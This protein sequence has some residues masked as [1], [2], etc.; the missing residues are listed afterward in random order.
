MPIRP[1][2]L[3]R[4][5]IPL[6]EMLTET[7]QYPENPD[8]SVRTDEKEHLVN[9]VRTI[10]RL[11]PLVRTMQLFSQPLRDILHGYVWEEEGEIVGM[12]IVQRRG[13]T[14]IWGV[15][16][17][18]VLPAFRRRGIARKTLQESLEL[19][20]RRGGTKAWLGVIDGNVPAQTLYERLGFEAYDGLSEYSIKPTEPPTVPPLPK[21]YAASRLD[22]NDWRTRYELE[23]RIAPE[24]TRLYEPIEVGR[25]RRPWMLR[26]LSP[27]MRFVRRAREEDFVIRLCSDAKVIAIAGYS[28][29]TRG[30]GVNRIW[31]RLD[32]EHPDLAPYVLGL[33]LDTVICQSPNLRIELSVPRWMPAVAEAAEALGFNRRVEYLKMGLVL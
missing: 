19:I 6:G 33:L 32:P 20:K 14:S 2:K 22:Q 24:S 11:W 9:E 27:I 5:L 3:P 1:M 23:K 12:T 7:F 4:D 17:V 8:W 15:G 10:R 16:T 21:G 30:K 25:F 18:G 28:A 13:T 29:S 31:I 26:A